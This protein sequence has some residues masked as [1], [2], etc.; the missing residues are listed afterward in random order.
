M[1]TN[2]CLYLMG[3]RINYWLVDCV[4]W[5]ILSPAFAEIITP[6]EIDCIERYKQPM[7][8]RIAECQNGG[9]YEITT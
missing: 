6:F 3:D 5:A 2:R 9:M 4:K 7:E 1:K 8:A